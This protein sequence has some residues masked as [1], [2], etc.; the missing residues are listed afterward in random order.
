MPRSHS[1]LV[2][3]AV[4]LRAE[5][6]SSHERPL[7]D[8]SLDLDAG[9]LVVVWGRRRSG[10]TT[11]LRVAAGLVAPHQG[12]VRFD[13]VDLQDNRAAVVGRDIVLCST[14]FPPELGHTVRDQVAAPLLGQRIRRR[15]ARSQA[16]LMLRRVEA[17]GC[18]ERSPRDLDPGE[19]VRVALARSLVTRPRLLLLDDPANGIDA[20]QR[21][22]I[23]ELIRSLVSE[24]RIAVLMTVSEVIY[25]GVA[26]RVLS[27]SDG[28]LRGD[29]VPKSA[30]VTPLRSARPSA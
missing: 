1:L 25:H 9:E 30:T 2:L 14:I 8:I 18:V 10:R 27:I 13:G 6:V 28:T 15:A 22:E 4:S 3:D 26:D 19:L 17:E 12:S 5:S 20:I 24:D 23:V 21:D 11:L 29:V 16:E 7:H